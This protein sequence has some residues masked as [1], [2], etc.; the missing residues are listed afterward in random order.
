M[1][2]DEPR[3]PAETGSFMQRLFGFGR[4][5]STPATTSRNER[6]T[7]P[8]HNVIPDSDDDSEIVLNVRQ[9]PPEGNS[10]THAN[11][12]QEGTNTVYTASHVPSSDR[13]D[14][15]YPRNVRRSTPKQLS[16]I[17][18]ASY[19]L[20]SV[21]AVS[22][23][24]T[25][26]AEHDAEQ[27]AP[28][29]AV[30]HDTSPEAVRRPRVTFRDVVEHDR[31]GNAM[32]ESASHVAGMGYQPPITL[33]DQ[34][35]TPMRV[36]SH[37]VEPIL[38]DSYGSTM[39]T[40]SCSTGNS[41]DGKFNVSPGYEADRSTSKSP[42]RR[43][44]AS[45]S[46][47]RDKRW[48]SPA[49]N[50]RKAY[51]SKL[52][53][54]DGKDWEAYKLHFLSC[55]I[56]NRWSDDDAAAILTSH[57]IGDAA[58]ALTHVPLQERTLAALLNVLDE[59]YD[60]VGP[61]YI[62]KGKLRRTV[63]RNNQPLQTFADSIMRVTWSSYGEDGA[64]M[65]LE[66]FIQGLCDPRMQKHVAKREPKSL[67]EALSIARQFEE[68]E[69]WVQ[70]SHRPTRRIARVGKNDVSS[71]SDDDDTETKRNNNP[72]QV[73]KQNKLVDRAG[74]NEKHNVDLAALLN[75]VRERM[76]RLEQSGVVNVVDRF[77]G[78]G[79]H[80]AAMRD[81]NWTGEHQAGS[82]DWRQPPNAN[83]RGNFQFRGRWN[84]RGRGFVRN[85][86]YRQVGQYNGQD[87]R[88]IP[89]QRAIEPPPQK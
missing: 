26:G 35:G 17:A 80:P 77:R 25:A 53:Y 9:Y 29:A 28:A 83:F 68:T 71:S 61:D 81:S 8:D 14:T 63:Q 22:P 89:G 12:V 16:H 58:F 15:P 67:P 19:E 84:P 82:A 2:G 44:Y 1:E 86:V 88:V 55:Q 46:R 51:V 39:S 27:R 42:E 11:R 30:G 49:D 20:P 5:A 13:D 36:T 40:S 72:K 85:N 66:Q 6:E 37:G 50:S 18:E 21:E 76:D 74:S 3:A 56:S 34:Y 47:N 79:G 59:R 43:R 52:R 57:L 31:P 32:D 4:R 60:L 78:T 7:N 87:P 65:A 48:Q 38:Y 64:K 33:Y 75:Q 23:I 70:T 45:P 69:S 24:E 54:F 73:T 10:D 41:T 62:I